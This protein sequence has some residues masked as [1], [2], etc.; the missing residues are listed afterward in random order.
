MT[1]TKSKTKSAWPPI[2]ARTY[3]SGETGWMV[4]CQVDGKRIRETFPTK[5]EAESRAAQIRAQVQSEGNAAFSLDSSIRV[6]AVR[7][8]EKLSPHNSTITEAVDHYVEHVLKYRTSPSVREIVEKLIADAIADR[9]R[10]STVIDLKSRLRTFA[11]GFGDRRVAGI[12]REELKD[13]LH[14]PTLSARSR[15]NNAVKLSQLWNYA[16]ANGWAEQNIPASIPHP[17]AEDG[18]PE[19]FT[20]E[21]AAGLLEHAEEYDLLGYIVLGLF[22]GLRTTELMRLDWSNVKL[23]ERSIIIGAKVAKK[24]SRRVVKIND[25]LAAWLPTCAK[26]K[27]PI[28]PVKRLCDRLPQRRKPLA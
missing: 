7:A 16:I 21:Q 17:T 18:E 25:T 1:T 13:W 20:V 6:E 5:G 11:K 23:A 2:A 12:T 24:H 10:E 15:I 28:L 4:A 9:R 19:I 26:T 14:N 8:V 3:P 22:A 27:G